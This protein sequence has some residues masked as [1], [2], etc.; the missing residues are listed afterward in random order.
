MCIWARCFTSAKLP[1]RFE[2]RGR[3]IEH[4]KSHQFRTEKV[5]E[6]SL[7]LQDYVDPL[8]L[9][10]ILEHIEMHVESTSS[11]FLQSCATPIENLCNKITLRSMCHGIFHNLFYHARHQDDIGDIV[12]QALQEETIIHRETEN[13]EVIQD[14]FQG[15]SLQQS[16]INVVSR[17]NAQLGKN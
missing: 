6:C 11:A 17:N 7:C 2:N 8:S 3:F 4:A 12:D 1:N 5:M 9:G 16:S 13:L 14:I 15:G 10:N